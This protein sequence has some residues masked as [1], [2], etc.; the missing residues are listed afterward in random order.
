MKLYFDDF[1]SFGTFGEKFVK[2][3]FDDFLKI[4]L[5]ILTTRIPDGLCFAN[6][7]ML[8]KIDEGGGE[9]K[10]DPATALLKQ[11]LPT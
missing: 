3:C 4:K 8:A 6:V 1:F 5:T 10:T 9:A 11:P 7:N 2:V